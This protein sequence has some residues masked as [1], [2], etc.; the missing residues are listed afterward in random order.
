M[1]GRLNSQ[2]S[3]PRVL[4]WPP[5]GQGLRS[6]GGMRTNAG[7]WARATPTPATQHQQPSVSGPKL[8]IRRPFM[9]SSG[10]WGRGSGGPGATPH[11]TANR[12]ARFSF[13]SPCQSLK[14]RS[15]FGGGLISRQSTGRPTGNRNPTQA[16]QR[17]SRRASWGDHLLTGSTKP[18]ILTGSPLVQPLGSV[19]C[20]AGDHR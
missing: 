17:T 3:A 5:P 4:S 6:E 20:A 10:R 9:V 14:H 8:F 19:R 1:G 11:H 12:P 2:D 16:K 13:P 15:A 7:C 18:L